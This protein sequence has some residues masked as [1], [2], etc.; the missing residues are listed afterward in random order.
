MMSSKPSQFYGDL[1]KYYDDLNAWKDYRAESA[2]LEG[3]IGE[4][5]QFSVALGRMRSP[6]RQPMLCAVP[7]V[8]LADRTR[9]WSTT[10]SSAGRWV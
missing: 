5:G 4:S 2:R 7:T 1:A 8:P 3:G 10:S 9:S 6:S